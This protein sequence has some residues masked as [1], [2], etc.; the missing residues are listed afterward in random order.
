MAKSQVDHTADRELIEIGVLW[1]NTAKSG[2][3]YWNGSLEDGR[4]IVVFTNT[5]QNHPSAP[6]HRI[7]VNTYT[8]EEMK[9]LAEESAINS[10]DRKAKAE[11]YKAERESQAARPAPERDEQAEPQ[12]QVSLPM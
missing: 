3:T 1:E 9:I 10:A 5:K 12:E 11:A 4:K 7:L 6:T 2:L 8:E